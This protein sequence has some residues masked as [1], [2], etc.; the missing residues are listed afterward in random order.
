METG[1]LIDRYR[2]TN[3]I[4]RSL[5]LIAAAVIV[6]LFILFEDGTLLSE[7]LEMVRQSHD[8]TKIKLDRAVRSTAELPQLEQRLAGIELGLD[9]ARRFLPKSIEFDEILAQTGL[10]E[11]ELGVQVV[12]FVPG[13]EAQPNTEM[14]Y[15]EVPVEITVRAEFGKA[16]QFFDRLVH[17]DKLTHLRNVSFERSRDVDADAGEVVAKAS[18][19]LFRDLG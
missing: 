13:A 8:A 11:K 6:P 19:I 18:L 16:M 4:M 9:R 7:E 17:M 10:F 1:E 12:R 14:R 3:S 5:L 2:N 15:A